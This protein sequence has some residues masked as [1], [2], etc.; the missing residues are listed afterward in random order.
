VQ[1]ADQDAGGEIEL[2]F[3][4]IRSKETRSKYKSYLKKYMEL[5]GVDKTK[6]CSEKD[7]R[8]IE[9]QIIDFINK[10]KNEGM[11]WGQLK[12]MLLACWHFTR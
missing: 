4:S 6:L 3:N 11:N 9:R 12:T 1:I 7:P 10:R 5:E 8:I 2:F